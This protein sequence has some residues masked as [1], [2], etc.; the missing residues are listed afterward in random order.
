MARV[1]DSVPTTGITNVLS[2]SARKSPRIRFRRKH[3]VIQKSSQPTP[4]TPKP[5]IPPNP[6]SVCSSP[7]QPAQNRLINHA[8]TSPT[9]PPKPGKPPQ[10]VTHTSSRNNDLLSSSPF[11]AFLPA[12]DAPSIGLGLTPLMLILLG[13]ASSPNGFFAGPAAAPASAPTPAPVTGD[14]LLG[15]PRSSSSC[16]SSPAK[17]IR[18]P[19]PCG[20]APPDRAC[21]TVPSSRSSS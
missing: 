12:N 17:F 20:G 3:A 16:S 14:R 19:S 15:R 2:G 6:S 7:D 9:K 5:K 1:S 18:Y 10:N 8:E 13:S 21:D 4:P 11:A